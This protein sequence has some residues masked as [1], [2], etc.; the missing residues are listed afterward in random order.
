M[1]LLGGKDDEE[2]A[3]FADNDGCSLVLIMGDNKDRKDTRKKEYPSEKEYSSKNA[4]SG[5]KEY[6]SKNAYTGKKEYTEE[7]VY[8]GENAYTGCKANQGEANKNDENVVECGKSRKNEE[9]VITGMIK[10]LEEMKESDDTSDAVNPGINPDGHQQSA[11]YATQVQNGDEVKRNTYPRKDDTKLHVGLDYSTFY[12][13]TPYKII[14]C[15][16]KGSHFLFWG[17]DTLCGQS[18][19]VTKEFKMNEMKKNNSEELRNSRF[20]FFDR[21]KKLLVL[22]YNIRSNSF[23][24]ISESDPIYMY[25][26]Q[27]HEK[28]FLDDNI[29]KEKKNSILIYPYTYVKIWESLTCYIN[30]EVINKI[31]PVN[32]T[33]CSSFLEAKEEEEEK[34]KKKKKV[35]ADLLREEEMNLCN[36]PYMFYSVIP[37]YPSS[38]TYP[39]EGRVSGGSR[40]KKEDN[41]G[42][43]STEIEGA[44]GINMEDHSV[45]GV[46]VEGGHLTCSDVSVGVHEVVSDEPLNF[47]LDSA[48]ESYFERIDVDSKH[49]KYVPSDLT[50]IH[51]EKYWILK[52]IIQ[53]EYTYVYYENE[54]KEGFHK[55]EN[56]LFYILGEFQFAYILFHLGFNYQSFVQWR[57]LFELLSNSQHL[58]TNFPDFFEE[59]LRVISIHLSYLSDDFFDNT[60]NSFILFGVYNIYEIVSGVGEVHEGITNVMNSIDSI[61]YAKLGLH[62]PDLSFVYEEY[63][64]TYVDDD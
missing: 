6:T 28:K 39:N 27:L 40:R 15:M 41:L 60:E 9:R 63:Q 23:N 38:K 8:P 19:Q 12:L 3:V 62:L 2:N 16:N 51:L 47:H 45:G 20:I 55:F 22:K 24:Y 42:V 10:I 25:F 57:K 56:K 49:K 11:E 5:K 59:A 32:K 7:N 46:N 58:V 17:S 4:Y 36:Q 64:P 61:I 37:R 35:G 1:N 33:F 30:E 48:N 14:K 54:K 53:Q 18:D 31:E 50:I 44:G 43:N 29:I 13:D 21:K 26:H 34:K 52:E